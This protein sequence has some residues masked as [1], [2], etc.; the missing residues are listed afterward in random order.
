MQAKDIEK[1]LAHLGQEL[2][3]LGMQEPVR[4]LM[5]GGAYMLLLA[6]APRST[7]DVDILWLGLEDSKRDQT[8]LA[9]KSAVNAV[10]TIHN[11]DGDWF[12]DMTDLLLH[13]LV[14]VPTGKLWRKYGLLHIHIPTKEYILALK[15]LA[16]RDKDISDSKLLLQ[17]LTITTRRQAQQLLDRYVPPATQAT[18][19]NEIPHTLD[20][21]FGEQ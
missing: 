4:V 6:K 13:D 15:I 2:A 5:I 11:I 14:R 7:D 9:I 10:A 12:N 16:G 17:Q 20:A 19:S 21:L 18:A 3:N 8:I 1:Y